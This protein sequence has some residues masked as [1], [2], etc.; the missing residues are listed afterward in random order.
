MLYSYKWLQKFLHNLPSAADVAGKLTASG[1]EVESVKKIY[2]DINGIVTAKIQNIKQH[3]GA[4]N[5]YIADIFTGS[6]LFQTVT[7]A[8]GLK[9]GMIVAYAPSGATISNG[10]IITDVSVTG[11]KSSGMIISENELNIPDAKR[12][13]ISFS[14]SVIPGKDVKSLLD[15]N[16]YILNVAVT[17]NRADVLSHLGLAREI[18]TLFHIRV[19]YPSYELHEKKY[20]K[21]NRPLNIRIESGQDCSRY[22]IRL[23]EGVQIKPSPLWLRITL[24][25]LEQKAINNVVD[26]TN[27]VMF[28]IGQ[29]LHAFDARKLQGNTIVVRRAGNEKL[30]TLDDQERLL[31][32]ETLVIADE[33]RPLALA[34]VIGGK[35][36][37]ITEQTTNV[38]LE[39]AAFSSSVIRNTERRLGILTEA[40]YRFERGIDPRLPENASNYASHLISQITGASVYRL[41][42][43]CPVRV[44]K[45]KITASV[46][47]LQTIVG[48]PLNMKRVQSLL[49][50]IYCDIKNTSSNTISV[51]PPSFRLDLVQPVDLAEE[52]A[53]LTGYAKI[54]SM[55]PLKRVSNVTLPS[56]YTYTALIKN[57]LVAIGFDEVVNYSFYGEKDHSVVGGKVIKLLN[58]LNEQ[59]TFMRTSLI[60][61]LLKNARYNLFRQVEY[62]R[63]FE[64][65]K[66][67]LKNGNEY[68][69]RI[70][71]AG[72]L[73]GTHYPFQWAS[74]HE[75]VDLFDAIGAIEGIVTAL[76]IKNAPAIESGSIN[77]LEPNN[78]AVLKYK[79]NRIGFAGKISKD[80]LR[81]YDIK[82]QIFVFN[83]ALEPLL[84]EASSYTKYSAVP[85]Y[86]FVSRDLTIV[87]P[88][89][90]FCY[91][92][93]QGIKSLRIPLLAEVFPFDLYVDKKNISEH[94]VTY[95]FIFRSEER[96]LKDEEVDHYM[97]KIMKYIT[98]NY[99]VKLKV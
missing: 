68:I 99:N 44:K 96:T 13:I 10:R 48:F 72:L 25:K 7:G 57:Y 24:G 94:S 40:D 35:F 64:I 77:F 56:D 73:T 22:T 46:N 2:T 42:N 93:T 11:E 45:H 86:P 43:N 21:Q 29:P 36:S 27:Y 34:G 90:L 79:N 20:N 12:E 51:E 62:Q 61:L 59:T 83:I 41:I 58:P 18:A 5:L 85:K 49:K 69:E 39:S 30:V 60:P 88:T 81:D 6:G 31:T 87:K 33:K 71:A 17:P 89:S 47:A 74:S 84:S 92:I 66:I 95:R 26:I 4:A 54:P 53:R 91:N 9:Q 32:N 38:L 76:K 23:I 67:Y 14:Q 16:D 3:P 8:T 50:S 28:A 55:L 82:Q 63:L 1:L 52:I 80:I 70:H 75:K 98:E 97:K 78:T 19:L 65:G 15:L 37:G